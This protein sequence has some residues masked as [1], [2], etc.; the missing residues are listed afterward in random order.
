M[1][2]K[3]IERRLKLLEDA[4]FRD[5][6]LITPAPVKPLALSELAGSSL[7][8]NGQQKI[9]VILG[10]NEL[11]MKGEP[12]TM[13]EI[14]KAWTTAKFDLKPDPKQLE[15]A[16]KAGLVRDANNT[17]KYDLARKGEAYFQTVVDGIDHE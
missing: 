15:R 13:S 17:K 11:I 12:L 7:I 5:T 1:D 16:I 8:S 14:R 9:V 6:Q 10:H 2:T 4:V 3:D